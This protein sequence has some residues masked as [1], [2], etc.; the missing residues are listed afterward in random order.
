MNQIIL[1]GSRY[2]TARRY[3]EE[4]SRRTGVPAVSYDRAPA[5]DGMDQIVYLGSLYAGGVT[6]LRQTLKNLPDRAELM[7]ATVGLADGGDPQ[8]AAHIRASLKKQLS[9]RFATTPWFHLRGSI[10]YRQLSLRHRAMMAALALSL[11]KKDPAQRS[12]GDRMI[13]DTYGGQIDLVDFSA[14]KPLADA[15][16]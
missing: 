15:I 2:G 9:S 10:D 6:G 8:S 5:L 14:L 11:R 4:L 16:K 1:Y 7:V 12:D 13:L 3:A